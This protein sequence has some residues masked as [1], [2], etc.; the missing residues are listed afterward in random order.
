MNIIIFGATSGIGKGL[1]KL[2]V[3]K[4]HKVAITGRRLDKLKEIQQTKPKNYVIKQH[5]VTE[6]ASSETVFE[7]LVATLSTIDIIVYSSGIGAL[8]RELNW[9]KELPTLETNILGAAKILGLSYQFFQKQG[10]GHIVGISSISGIRGNAHAPA[11]AA[12][13]S[14]LSNYLE[15]LW[16]KGKKSQSNIVVTDIIP[17]FVDTDMAQGETFWMSSTQKAAKQ[18]FTAIKKKKRRAY[19]TKRWRIIALLLKIIPARILLKT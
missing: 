16:I 19:I 15:S 6:I 17:G 13:K 8:N 14:F 11:Y 1:A 3:D 18:I 2:F 12:S 9:Q 4:G 5:D 10:Y 7:E